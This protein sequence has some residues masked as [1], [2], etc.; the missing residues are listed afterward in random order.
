MYAGDNDAVASV[1]VAMGYDAPPA[2]ER[3]VPHGGGVRGGSFEN[4]C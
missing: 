3:R 2:P 1:R 4:I